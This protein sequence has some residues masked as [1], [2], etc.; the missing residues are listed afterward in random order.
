MLNMNVDAPGINPDTA[1]EETKIATINSKTTPL[2]QFL[3]T[4]TV[5]KLKQKLSIT[6]IEPW[7]LF[8]YNHLTVYYYFILMP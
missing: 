1:T 6:K 3:K 4:D 8:T 5:K 2:K 7:T